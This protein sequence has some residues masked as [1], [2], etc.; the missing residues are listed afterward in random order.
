MCKCCCEDIKKYGKI[1]CLLFFGIIFLIL[2]TI[3]SPGS[4]NY[5]VFWLLVFVA[6]YFEEIQSVSVGV[7]NLEK[8]E[9]IAN[10]VDASIV[11]IYKALIIGVVETDKGGFSGGKIL[12]AKFLRFMMVF[13]DIKKLPQN[14]QG[15]LD[16]SVKGTAL[17]IA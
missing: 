3:F 9:K 12:N 14:I 7:F 6:I 2:Q 5:A 13:D 16:E 10:H 11:T 15:K 17:K 8:Y 1:V 4:Y